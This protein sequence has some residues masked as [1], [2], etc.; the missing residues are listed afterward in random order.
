MTDATTVPT[1]VKQRR[2]SRK[3]AGAAEPIILGELQGL[4]GYHLRCAQVTLFQH[5]HKA[6][7]EFELTPPQYGTMLLIEA[8]PGI[9]QSAVSETLRFD[10]STLVPIIDRLEERG[11][12]VRAVAAQDRRSHALKLTPGGEALLVTLK[13]ISHQ[14]EGDVAR[15]LSPA[16]Q[17]TLRRL[18][19]AIHSPG[20]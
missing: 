3:P 15:Q 7:A 2:P 1:R 14:H 20:Q 19:S 8:N 9:S 10:R 16:E 12:V 5:Y 4:L 18:L 6:F 11:L 13:K 17:A